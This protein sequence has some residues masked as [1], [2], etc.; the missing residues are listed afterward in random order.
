MAYGHILV[1]HTDNGSVNKTKYVIDIVQ[2][3]REGGYKVYL[4]TTNSSIKYFND[5]PFKLILSW[6]PRTIFGYYQEYLV[7]IRSILLAVYACWNPP[8]GQS[9]LVICDG[10]TLTIPL[11][12]YFKFH[13]HFIYY[14]VSFHRLVT[15]VQDVKFSPFDTAC[16]QHADEVILPTHECQE[17]LNCVPIK[18]KLVLPP[19]V[20]DCLSMNPLS[21][22]QLP[23]LNKFQHIFTVFGEY[24][25]PDSMYMVLNAFIDLKQ[26][27]SSA[28]FNNTRLVFVGRCE[29]ER[30]CE[31]MN[32]FNNVILTQDPAI[33]EKIYLYDTSDTKTIR[34]FLHHSLAL[35]DV[36][37]NSL[38]DVMILRAQD[39][40]KPVIC[41][42]SGF[43]REV[44]V[45]E[46]TGVYI[47]KQVQSVR[48]SMHRFICGRHWAERL[49]VEARRNIRNKY[50]MCTFR[51]N[52]NN[53]A[54]RS[55]VIK[56][57]TYLP[58]DSYESFLWNSSN[59]R[60]HYDHKICE[61]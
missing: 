10:S 37:E 38:F 14:M 39:M 5:V 49:G 33:S 30:E 43:N 42:E 56:N 61:H 23:Q 35:I 55:K 16:L 59:Y 22:L 58:I 48:N 2:G 36:N 3:L 44:I 60:R 15:K 28:L 41:F 53:F 7:T 27:L 31:E 47:T 13:V 4:L 45:K 8:K 46:M 20:E 52:V 18:S 12:K 17:Q 26:M 54:L 50:S 6:F 32:K 51:E 24:L 11:L 34:S 57:K 25:N 21:I 9:S 29:T 40:G 19:C 1:L